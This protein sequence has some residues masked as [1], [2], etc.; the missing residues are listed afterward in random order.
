MRYPT[1]ELVFGG[2]YIPLEVNPLITTP[3]SVRRAPRVFYG[4]WIVAAGF[5]LQALG[6]GLLFNSFGAYFVFLQNE[7]GWSRTV[8]SGAFSMSRLES[9]FLGPIQAWLIN[10]F[11]P[12]AVVRFGLVVFGLGFIL[13]SRLDSVLGFYGAFLVIAIGS[14]L[15]GFLT[16]N[17]VLANWFERQRAR[18]MA[19]SSAGVSISGL[20]V[21]LVAWALAT[22][23][24]RTTALVSGL[25]I[26]V[27]GLPISQLIRRSPETYG[28]APDGGER[29]PSGDDSSSARIA[30]TAGQGL[31]AR[32]AL[33]TPAF[34]LLTAGHA[35]ALVAV[36][37]ASAHVIPF[38]VAQADMPVAAAA[39]VVATVTTV[40]LVGVLITSYIGDR[41]AKP[42]IAACCMVAHTAAVLMLASAQN[43]GM[44]LGFA[45][46][47]G[48]AWGI[49]GPLMMAV[50]ADY[51]GRRSF[52]TI[53]GFA[54]IVTTFG[55]VTG[56]LLV[57]FVADTVGDYRPGFLMLAGI[58]AAGGLCFLAARRPV[59]LTPG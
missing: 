2:Q 45:V 42:K 43:L 46:L 7:F 50:R 27:V 9:G 15:S 4:W 34:W 19:L 13:L 53:E 47:H 37:A 52:A 16:V 21:P 38:L 31:T 30:S 23:G 48:L 39:G 40:Q 51:F 58:T 35:S 24:W 55:L 59:P 49:R 33:H 20:L 5:V 14:G 57:G 18:A 11:G 12:R 54:S 10:R 6:S 17:I 22:Y 29:P 1:T 8:L 26:L 28:Y 56:P 32:A 36:S 25:L 44:I 41:F 3:S